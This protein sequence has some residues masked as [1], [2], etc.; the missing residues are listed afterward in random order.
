MAIYKQYDDLIKTLKESGA[1][2]NTIRPEFLLKYSEYNFYVKNNPSQY[3][4]PTVGRLNES[5][6]QYLS[7]D[8][9]ITLFY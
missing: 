4:A 3:L 8:A 7:T 5:K 9:W 1:L 2:L 6:F